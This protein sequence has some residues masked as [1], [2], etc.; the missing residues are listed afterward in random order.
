MLKDLK[1]METLSELGVLFLLYEQGL[2]LSLD[3]LKVG[4][5]GRVQAGQ[6]WPTLAWRELAPCFLLQHAVEASS[7]S[8]WLRGP[9]AGH[10]DGRTCS[11]PCVLTCSRV[12]AV[13]CCH[14]PLPSCRL[15]PST[16]LAWA[17]CR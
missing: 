13:T 5:R 15:W 17:R 3:R 2:E 6:P 12:L 7:G 4:G 1:D 9:G 10:S 11:S 14:L 16:P 8:V